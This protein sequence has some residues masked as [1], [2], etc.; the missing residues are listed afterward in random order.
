MGV[1]VKGCVVCVDECMTLW[2]LYL[3]VCLSVST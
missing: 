2:F 1:F 3:F